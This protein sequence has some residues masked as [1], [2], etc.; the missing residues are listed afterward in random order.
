MQAEIGQRDQEIYLV[1]Q[2]EENYDWENLSQ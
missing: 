2:K 1:E